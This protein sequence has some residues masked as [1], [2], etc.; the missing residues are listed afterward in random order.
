MRFSRSPFSQAALFEKIL[1]QPV[2]L[3][4]EEVIGLVDE[5]EGDVAMT[6][7]GRVSANSR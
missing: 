4:G 5:T 3:P 7:G 2:D 6:S 1:F